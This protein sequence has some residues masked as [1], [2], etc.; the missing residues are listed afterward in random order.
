ME[1]KI[2]ITYN[3]RKLINNIPKMTANLILESGNTSKAET[4]KNIRIEKHKKPLSNVTIKQRLKGNHPS[5]KNIK[6]SSI[7]P[8]IWS[9][10][11]YNNIQFK[12]DI[13]SMP[14]YGWYHH[15]GTGWGKV[16]RPFIEM[17]VTNRALKKF[18]KELTKNFRK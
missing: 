7:K 5:G 17:R 1:V 12:Q 9:K 13:L 11:L 2:E 6:T 18:S 4:R 3:A 16:E 10:N 8:L 14:K 15:K